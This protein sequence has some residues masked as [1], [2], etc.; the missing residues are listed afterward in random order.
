MEEHLAQIEQSRR[1]LLIMERRSALLQARQAVV[2]EAFVA[3]RASLR[4]DTARREKLYLKL[5]EA[6]VEPEKKKVKRWC[7]PEDRHR[8]AQR[9][10]GRIQSCA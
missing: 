4:L 9:C 1:Q 7:V 5:A 3:A 8:S 6:A 2:E 10:S